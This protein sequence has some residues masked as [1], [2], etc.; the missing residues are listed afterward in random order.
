M[1]AGRRSSMH[2]C[3]LMKP[4]QSS[5][6]P[7]PRRSSRQGFRKL[8]PSEY[9]WPQA[10]LRQGVKVPR[11]GWPVTCNSAGCGKGIILLAHA[12]GGSR[13]RRRNRYIRCSDAG[14]A[15]LLLDLLTEAEGE[16]DLRTRISGSISGCLRSEVQDAAAW[17]SRESSARHFPIGFFGSEAKRSIRNSPRRHWSRLRRQHPRAD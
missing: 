14:L 2:S 4:L 13:Y 12:S 15:T 10:I 8:I 11:L 7:T 17:L 6:F 1:G 5:H 9:S 16:V 3:I